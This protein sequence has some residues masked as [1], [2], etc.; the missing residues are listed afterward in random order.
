VQSVRE[1]IGAGVTLTFLDKTSLYVFILSNALIS[2]LDQKIADLSNS[3]ASL[4]PG[5]RV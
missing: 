4:D 2:E 5:S 3:E 1:K